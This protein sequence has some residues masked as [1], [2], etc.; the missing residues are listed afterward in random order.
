MIS[1]PPNVGKSAVAEALCDR[2]DRMLHLDVGVMRDFLR[3]GRLRPD[4]MSVE[5]R[6]QRKLFIASATDMACRF[7]DAG[8]GVVIDDVITPDDL[9]AYVDG[10]RLRDEPKHL[11]VLLP[12]DASA[13]G[14]SRHDREMHAQLALWEGVALVD[15]TGLAPEAVAD[16]VMAV[17]A[18]GQALIDAK[19]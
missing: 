1:G 19:G 2:Y 17:A 16:R 8:Y 13:T 7:L 18:E 12:N 14:R 3:M 11:V 10:L 5:A 6:H 4:D 15:P 9:P